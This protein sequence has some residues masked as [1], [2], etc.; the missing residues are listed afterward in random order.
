MPITISRHIRTCYYSS[1]YG[2]FSKAIQYM[3]KGATY[4]D[5]E[6]SK[7]IRSQSNLVI[8]KSQAI[9]CCKDLIHNLV[10]D[11]LRRYWNSYLK[12]NIRKL[13]KNHN[14]N[15]AQI[16]YKWS[17]IMSHPNNYQVPTLDIHK[18]MLP[19]RVLG[20]EQVANEFHCSP[21]EEHRSAS[22]TLSSHSLSF[23]SLTLILPSP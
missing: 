2:S 17:V 20:E 3:R 13:P 11:I 9:L 23:M 18:F 22:V 19:R 5:N 21:S 15:A 4:E 16:A 12:K 1:K 14:A 7:I 10:D 6:S 8:L